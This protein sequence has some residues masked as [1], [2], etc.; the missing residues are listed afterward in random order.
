[1][2]PSRRVSGD[3]EEADRPPRREG[4]GGGQRHG[5]RGRRGGR[6]R[7]GRGQE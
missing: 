6:N 7:G 2:R 5:G 1:M 4:D 3:D